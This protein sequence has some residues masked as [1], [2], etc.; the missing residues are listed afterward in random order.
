MFMRKLL[1]VLSCLG[2]DGGP[3]AYNTALSGFLRDERSCSR[4]L[5]EKK[6]EG[7]ELIE[8][9]FLCAFY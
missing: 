3:G 2:Q 9:L 7:T 1:H 8:C 4:V 6:G 5:Q